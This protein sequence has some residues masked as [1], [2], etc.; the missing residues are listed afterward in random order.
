MEMYQKLFETF[1]NYAFKATSFI[2][3]NPLRVI[4]RLVRVIQGKSYILWIPAFAGITG[5][6][7]GNIYDLISC[8]QEIS[9][10]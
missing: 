1:R 5:G 10:D 7:N 6:V 4:T 3:L 8:D 2:P 9:L